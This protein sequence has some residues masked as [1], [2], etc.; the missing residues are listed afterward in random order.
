L[1]AKFNQES[2]RISFGIL[3][4]RNLLWIFVSAMQ[5]KSFQSLFIGLLVSLSALGQTPNWSEDVAKVVYE[6]CS[7]C[8]RTGGV[9][10]FPL[11]SFSDA[12]NNQAQMAN[13]VASRRMPP[14]PPDTLAHRFV[15]ERMLTVE[16]A[17]LITNWV[18]GGAPRGDST[19]A[20]DPPTFD[21]GSGL[22]TPDLNLRMP[23]YTSKAAAEDDYICIS[24]PSGLTSD[25]V[26]R[27]M[28]VIPGNQ[29]IVHHALIFIDTTGTVQTDTGEC[30]VPLNSKL[31]GGWVPGAGPA[32]F[33]STK[34]FAMGMTIPAGSNVILQMHYPEGSAGMKDSTRVKLYF[35]PDGTPNIR[36]IGASSL[37]QNWFLSIPPNTVQTFTARYPGSGTMVD[38]WT[39]LSIFPHMHLLGKQISVE[40]RSPGDTTKLIN[41]PD[42]DF[43][44]QGF[45]TFKKP[46]KLPVGSYLYT[47]AL[48]D[49][50]IS[51]P[52]NPNNPPLHVNAG[53][54]TTDEMYLVYFLYLPYQAGDEHLNVDSIM[55]LPLAIPEPANGMLFEVSPNPFTERTLFRFN[56]KNSVASNIQVYDLQGRLVR[57]LLNKTLSSGRHTMSWNG[58]D[59]AGQ[60]VPD[61]VYVL[62][63]QFGDHIV[64]RKVIRINR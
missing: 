17:N 39:L 57:E 19:L 54:S 9:A 63:G 49:N 52:H 11:L 27:A 8:H 38:D 46:A 34:D 25:K 1:A 20:P 24:I 2:K 28:E 6:K 53:L 13:E 16:E 35:Y 33:P 14:W 50:T 12:F 43:E 4:Y 41:I 62:R 36:N 10:P 55:N 45:Y 37:L 64:N 40:I 48:Y 61:G 44:W 56:L 15:H 26:I 23:T 42:W 51:N 18:S 30:V 29:A 60:S 31:I 3:E 21:G 5:S 59:A 47:N 7:G 32:I 22:G 58:L